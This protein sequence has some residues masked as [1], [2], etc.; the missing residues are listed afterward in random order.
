MTADRRKYSRVKFEAETTC[1][2]Q[3]HRFATHLLDISLKGALVEFDS[4]PPFAKGAD[5][6]LE[7]A[8]NGR[9]LV[10][11]FEAHSVFESGSQVGLEFLGI[12]L[13]ALTHLRRLVELNTGDSDKVKEELFFL[14]THK[15]QSEP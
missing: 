11:S 2:W 10:L 4:H 14:A 12:D 6:H 9:Q 8:L 1:I 7:L 5:C 15:Q 3:G 13:E